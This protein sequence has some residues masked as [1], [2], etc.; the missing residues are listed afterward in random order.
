MLFNRGAF[1]RS[2][3]N[4][5]TGGSNP[6]M[7]GGATLTWGVY[8]TQPLYTNIPLS[9]AADLT[10]TTSGTIT[11]IV[12][13]SGTAGMVY[14]SGTDRRMWSDLALSGATSI[15]F[16][17]AGAIQNSHTFSFT[18]SGL[19]LQSGGSVVIDTDTLDIFVNGILNVMCWQHGGEFFEL[20]PGDND[21]QVY[22]DGDGNGELTIQWKDR[23][24]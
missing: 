2:T 7:Y 17:V 1:N 24:Y 5:D 10:Y 21:I 11:A 20:S 15:T 9:G 16:S 6:A 8:S 23:W 18:L 19:D 4:R 3:F 22:T 12:P 14:T 13:F